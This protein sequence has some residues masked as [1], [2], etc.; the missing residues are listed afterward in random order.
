MLEDE[1]SKFQ[2]EIT[3]GDTYC[4]FEDKLESMVFLAIMVCENQDCTSVSEE[5]DSNQHYIPVSG[6]ANSASNDPKSSPCYLAVLN[7]Q[8]CFVL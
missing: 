6:L 4:Y 8:F 3:E 5:Q 2:T 1:M 7:I